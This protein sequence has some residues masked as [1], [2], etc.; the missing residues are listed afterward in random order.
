V[1]AAAVAAE[2]FLEA[3]AARTPDG[4]ELA[5][6]LWRVVLEHASVLPGA[7]VVRALE[8]RDAG[9]ADPLWAAR[10]VT[11]AGLVLEGAAEASAPKALRKAR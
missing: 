7:W 3:A 2:A 10:T 1:T 11:L 4:G 5:A 9:G 8:L 6:E